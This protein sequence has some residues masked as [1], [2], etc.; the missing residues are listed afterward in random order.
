M[1]DYEVASSTLSI[2]ILTTLIYNL[3]TFLSFKDILRRFG[4]MKNSRRDFYECG[5]K[6]QTQKPIKVSIQFLIICVFFLLY[7]IE[8]VFLFPFVSG[9]TFLG[10]YDTLLLIL[11]F[12]VLYISL[13]IDYE[14]HALY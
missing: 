13:Q 9:I 6:P 4:F 11:F 3:L 2:F 5:F 10:L 12:T 7:D 14:R 8:L 1:G